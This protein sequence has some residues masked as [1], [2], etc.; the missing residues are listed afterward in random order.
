M[1]GPEDIKEI[2]MDRFFFGCEADDPMNALAFAKDIN[3]GGAELRAI[4]ASDIGH[5]DVQDFRGVLPEAWELVEEGALDASQFRAFTCDN[6]ARLMTSTNPDFFKG[7]AVEGV[8]A[9]L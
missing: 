1:K 6:A 2:F 4:F 3:P 7:T 5:W 9:D 8:V